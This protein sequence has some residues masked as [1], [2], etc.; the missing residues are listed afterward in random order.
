MRK[1]INM[2][3]LLVAVIGGVSFWYGAVVPWYDEQRRREIARSNALYED[4]RTLATLLCQTVLNDQYQRMLQTKPELALKM[5]D[6]NRFKS[7][8]GPPMFILYQC[9]E[10]E[11]KNEEHFASN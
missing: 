4:T 10:R 1:L 7:P 3:W 2:V 11:T 5:K 9:D 6:E 8:D